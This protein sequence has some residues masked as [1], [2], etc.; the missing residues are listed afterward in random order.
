RTAG[1]VDQPAPLTL[2]RDEDLELVEKLADGNRLRVRGAAVQRLDEED[3]PAPGVGPESENLAGGVG[4]DVP[5][6]AGA[7]GLEAADLDGTTPGAGRPRPRVPVH[8]HRPTVVPDDV[9]IVLEVRALAVVRP[10][11]LLV[12]D[13]LG[14]RDVGVRRPMSAA[15]AGAER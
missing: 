5:A 13:R 15:V 14:A 10:H 6:D 4:L 2:G 12:G 7:L 1:D 11:H 8:E 3:L 9:D